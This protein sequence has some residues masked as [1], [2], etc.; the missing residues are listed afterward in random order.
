MLLDEVAPHL[1]WFDLRLAEG[2]LDRAGRGPVRGLVADEVGQEVARSGEG[3]DAL[4][5]FVLVFEIGVVRGETLFV[6]VAETE[7]SGQGRLFLL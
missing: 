1:C 2:A 7:V 6:V 3:L 4:H 5:A